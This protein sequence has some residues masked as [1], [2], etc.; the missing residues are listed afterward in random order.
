M[1]AKGLRLAVLMGSIALQ[2]APRPALAQTPPSLGAAQSFAVLGGQ[3]VTN[4]GA[5]IITPDGN[6]SY[7]DAGVLRR[8]GRA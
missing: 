3:T 5:T 4:T 2:C 8:G 6:V 7:I 1:K